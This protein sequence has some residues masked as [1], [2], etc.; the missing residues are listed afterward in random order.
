MHHA[1][2]VGQ[3]AVDGAMEGEAGRVDRPAAAADDVAVAIHLDQVGR[4]HLGVV[5]A[6]GVQQKVPRLAGHPQRQV[7]VDQ[8]FPAQV[9]KDAVGR[10]QLHPRRPFGRGDV[11]GAGVG[12][13]EVG[14]GGLLENGQLAEMDWPLA[15]CRQITTIGS[16]P[17]T[18]MA[19]AAVLASARRSSAARV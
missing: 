9:R 11:F 14:H 13:I 2:G 16:R 7:V 5:Q 17:T 8:L 15:I 10:R 4:A 6:E 3:G 19:S 18:T 1:M 12:G